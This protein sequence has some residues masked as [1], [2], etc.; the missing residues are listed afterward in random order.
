M[1]MSFCTI[2]R[3]AVNL[4]IPKKPYS[5]EAKPINLYIGT[6]SERLNVP[7]IWNHSTATQNLK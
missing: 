1:I 3:S 6:A 2:K 4:F 5:P 7:L